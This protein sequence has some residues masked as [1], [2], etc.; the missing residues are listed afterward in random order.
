VKRRELREQIFQLLFRIEFHEEAEMSNQMKLFFEDIEK[1]VIGETD[2]AYIGDKFLNICTKLPEIDSIINQIA[3][4]WKT[5]RM[6]K[7]DLTIIRL[8]VY[9]MKF[10][11][12]VP[13]NVAINE[14]VELAKKFGGD[15][16]SAFVN[17]ILA[18]LA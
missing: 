5:N 6:S 16:S 14:A 7:V 4:G 10:D 1:V 8:A 12:E 17:G 3:E 15:D 11:D 2:K 13:V 9:E 18:K